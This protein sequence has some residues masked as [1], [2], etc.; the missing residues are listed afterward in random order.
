[1]MIEMTTD[2]V[3]MAMQYFANSEDSQALSDGGYVC[4]LYELEP[5]VT[6]EVYPAE[7]GLDVV[8]AFMLCY[9]EGIGGYYLGEKLETK[10]AL[11]NA[12]AGWSF[13]A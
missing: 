7:D 13:G 12:L 4:D 6:L 1:M 9:D 11:V 2:K 3:E 5:P 10:E 8:A